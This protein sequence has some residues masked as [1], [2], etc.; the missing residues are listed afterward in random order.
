MGAVVGFLTKLPDELFGLLDLT[1]EGLLKLL[2]LLNLLI[3][4]FPIKSTGSLFSTWTGTILWVS[5][6]LVNYGNYKKSNI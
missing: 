2:L 4:I 3:E 1:L 6:A 5:I